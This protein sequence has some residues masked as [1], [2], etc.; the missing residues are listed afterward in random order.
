MYVICERYV[1]SADCI[2]SLI[3]SLLNKFTAVD[4]IQVLL[5]FNRHENIIT[6][7]T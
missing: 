4:Y 7:L 2:F 3:S 1:T 5:V 6:L